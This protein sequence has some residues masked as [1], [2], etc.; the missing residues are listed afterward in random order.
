M[1]ATSSDSADQGSAGLGSHALV[2]GSF[3]LL[4]VRPG[5]L[6][7]FLLLVAMPGAPIVAS[8]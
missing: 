8:C 3:L 4:V 5:P 1:D 6:V 7:A 2:T